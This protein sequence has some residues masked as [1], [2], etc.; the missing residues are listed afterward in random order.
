MLYTLNLSHNSFTGQIPSSLR[1]FSQFEALDLSSNKLTGE[2]PLLVADGLIFFSVFNLSYNRLVGK[3]PMIKQ[4]VTFLD[5]SYEGNE[6]LCD[7]PLRKKCA[8]E[9]Q[10]GSSPPTSEATHSKPGVEID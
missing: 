10:P 2:L 1:K 9:D 7:F 5:T 8:D 4:F 3:I 6:G